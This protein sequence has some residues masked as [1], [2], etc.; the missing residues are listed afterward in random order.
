MIVFAVEGV[1]VFRLLLLCDLLSVFLINLCFL[2]M[3][4]EVEASGQPHVL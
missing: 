3:V 4:V 1:A 2:K